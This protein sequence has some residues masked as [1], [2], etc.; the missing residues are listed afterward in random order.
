MPKVMDDLSEL[1]TVD[2]MERD[3]GVVPEIG[4][5]ELEAMMRGGEALP[6][7]NKQPAKTKRPFYKRG[8]FMLL[9]VL[10]LAIGLIFG[11]RYYV[12]ASAHEATDD[13][14]IEGHV[15]QISPKVTGHIAKVYVT[16]NQ[17]V[18]K[19]DLLAEIDPRDYQARLA[20][21]KATELA[22]QSQG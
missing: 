3:L 16:D 22:A 5:D 1:K 8:R 17:H 6:P 13:A 21:A 7:D 4:D 12:H 9:I 19:G 15:V 20:Q 11:V 10:F 14:F 2:V 18:K